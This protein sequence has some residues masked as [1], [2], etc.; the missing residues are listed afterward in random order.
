MSFW[1]RY[2]APGDVRSARRTLEV[3]HKKAAEGAVE[4]AVKK[5]IRPPRLDPHIR[6]QRQN[7][8]LYGGALFTVLSVLVT[9]RAVARKILEAPSEVTAKT[10]AMSKSSG[11]FDA[12]QALSLATLNVFSI[13]LLAL[14]AVFKTFDIADIEDMR[15]K[16]RSGIG[17]DVYGGDDAADK[18]LEEWVRDN[19][20][21]KDG[22]GLKQDIVA[23]LAELEKFSK[24]KDEK[25]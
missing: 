23:K 12:A 17:F 10:Q 13:G 7:A 18:E 9:R 25:K 20:L 21:T 6:A 1:D 15:D 22:G 11:P 24:E 16:V 5:P 14:G 4:E 8:L 19:L 2:L 3:Q